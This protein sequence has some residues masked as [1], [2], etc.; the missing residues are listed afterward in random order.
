MSVNMPITT[1]KEAMTWADMLL[2]ELGEPPPATTALGADMVH[3]RWPWF[4]VVDKAFV[5]D[6]L[7]MR[8]V[9][10]EANEQRAQADAY[11]A[12]PQYGV[13]G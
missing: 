2:K 4:S 10:Y 6:A 3:A 13:W 7:R 11:Q 1:S 5:I 12:L 8:R 9:K